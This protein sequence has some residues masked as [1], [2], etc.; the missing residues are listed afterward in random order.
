LVQFYDAKDGWANAFMTIITTWTGLVVAVAYTLKSEHRYQGMRQQESDYYDMA[1]KF[2]DSLHENDPD[3]EAKVESYLA[4]T[5]AIRRTA[6]KVE[7]GSPPSATD[8]A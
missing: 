8:S 7:T 5:Q 2:L 4:T 3:L 6:R 1:R